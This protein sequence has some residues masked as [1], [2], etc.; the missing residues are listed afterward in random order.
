[1][2][3]FGVGQGP[4]GVSVAQCECSGGWNKYAFQ[5][6]AYRQ[7][8]WPPLDVST[9]GSLSRGDSLFRASLSRG[10]FL[11]GDPLPCGQNDLTHA[12]ENIA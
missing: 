10:L 6:D 4:V 11:E 5:Y 2:H 12:S 3:V 9:G 8:W 1:M 7:L